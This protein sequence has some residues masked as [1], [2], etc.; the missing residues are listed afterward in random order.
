MNGVYSLLSDFTRITKLD[1]YEFSQLLRL[2]FPKY[3]YLNERISKIVNVLLNAYG[4][5][6][7]NR[8]D[9]ILSNLCKT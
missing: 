7:S 3:C 8:K 9:I 4:G 6:L 1:Y 2:G 5:F